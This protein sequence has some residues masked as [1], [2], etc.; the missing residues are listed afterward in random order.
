MI[1][2]SKKK[3]IEN[4]Q[5]NA[6][7]IHIGISGNNGNDN[8][9]NNDDDDVDE[10]G[11]IKGLI[12]YEYE[13]EPMK[14]KLNKKKKKKNKK[15]QLSEIFMSYIFQSAV[16]NIN[17]HQMKQS[18]SIDDLL[19]DLKKEKSSNVIIKKSSKPSKPSKP[20]KQS[21]QKES[22]KQ[23]QQK[24]SSKQSQ[25][26]I[27]DFFEDDSDIEDLTVNHDSDEDSHHK[28][29][30]GSLTE[31][32]LSG[33]SSSEHSDSEDIEYDDSDED[34]ENEEDGE[35]GDEY[36]IDELDEQYLYLNDSETD[37][38]DKELYYFHNLDKDIKKKHLEDLEIIQKIN[39]SE[40]PL[41]FKILNSNMDLRTKS[42]AINNINKLDEMDVSTGEYC[43]MDKWINGLISIPFGKYIDLPINNKNNFKDKKDFIINTQTILNKAIY[44]HIDAKNHILELIGKWIKNPRSQGNVLAIQGPMGNGK[45]TLVK[46]GIAKAIN[47]PF[48]FIALGGA[49]DSSFFNG[50][51]YTYEGS[52]WG[53]IIDILMECKCM[54]PV[55]YFDELDKV[56]ETFKGEE[57]IHLLTHL[58]DPSQNTLYQDNYFPGIHINLSKALFIF[59][60]ND[61]SKVNRILK[62]RMYVINTK[63][64]QLK[65]KI[66]ISRNFLLPELLHSFLF[67]NNDIIFPNETFEYIIEKYTNKEEGVRNLKR[68]L[69]TILSKINIYNLTH[70]KNKENNHLN[71]TIKDFK[72]PIHI[73]N[74]LI[75]I[76]LNIKENKNKPPD[77]MYV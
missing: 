29:S 41:K 51:S 4:K 55:I 21:K 27:N 69:E 23:S 74:D 14:Y 77:H 65:D 22:S 49:S 61:E 56:S 73:S 2:R 58:T 34:H 42:I 36:D 50:H 68:C 25:Q 39:N 20:P 1:T 6:T 28:D 53:R 19:F 10:Y 72:L 7:N 40:T 37:L 62:D 5:K 63:G 32:S 54:N 26:D 52:H 43:K 24:E 60:F 47:R 8:D 44:G 59:S 66:E 35:D 31:P 15:N 46:E 17:N 30:E 13:D 75:D 38:E 48:A 70:E 9:N 12:D 3:D 18:N 57:I 67:T 64:F 11:N 71:F 33:D 76:L 16:N 45:T